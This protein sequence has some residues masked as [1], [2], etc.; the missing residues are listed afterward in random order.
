MSSLQSC[1]RDTLR[2]VCGLFLSASLLSVIFL[3]SNNFSKGSLA[4]TS[5]YL[6]LVIRPDPFVLDSP[7]WSHDGAP[8]GH[9]VSFFRMTFDPTENLENA[10][11]HIFA[12]TRYEVWMDGVWVGRGPARFSQNYRENDLY[13]IGD[14]NPGQHLIAVLVQ[15]A[16]N[17]RRSESVRP[18]L[19]AHIE[20]DTPSGRRLSFRDPRVLRG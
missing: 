11:L 13:Q 19:Q 2:W 10:E 7:I 5:V 8:A 20:G 16:P 18:L 4:V 14:L 3:I 17:N 9:E 12:D 15:W 6:P 1:P